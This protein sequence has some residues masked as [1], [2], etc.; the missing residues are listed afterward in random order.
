MKE[1]EERLEAALLSW[2]AVSK[3]RM[4]GCDAYLVRGRMF[5][6]LGDMGL[7]LKPPPAEREALL[8]RPSVQ[9]FMPRGGMPFGDWLQWRLSSVEE[10]EEALRPLRAAYEYVQA[11]PTKKGRRPTRPL[12]RSGRPRSESH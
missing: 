3:R 7:V 10:L 8:A 12:M 1:I 5:G 4:F 9:P 2:E 11:G 6:F